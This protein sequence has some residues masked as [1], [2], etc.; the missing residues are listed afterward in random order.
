M[1]FKYLEDFTSCKS[2]PLVNLSQSRS[3]RYFGSYLYCLLKN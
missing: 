1:T 3:S 2:F